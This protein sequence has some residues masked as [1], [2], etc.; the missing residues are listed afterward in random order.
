MLPVSTTSESPQV[1]KAT[2]TP[3]M[4]ALAK[5]VIEALARYEPGCGDCV[6]PK[7][8]AT[9]IDSLAKVFCGT[10]KNSL[11][12]VQKDAMNL[13]VYANIPMA[14]ITQFVKWSGY[15]IEWLSDGS[16]KVSQ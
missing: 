16:P 3:A 7:S 11:T 15:K 9:Q 12:S 2:P 5:K 1:I 13:F 8:Q 4:V 14:D 10:E 6:S